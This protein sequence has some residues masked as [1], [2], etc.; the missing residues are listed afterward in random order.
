MRPGI[1]HLLSLRFVIAIIWVVLIQTTLS[2]ALI[3]AG[4]TTFIGSFVKCGGMVVILAMFAVPLAYAICP[5]IVRNF[6]FCSLAPV[7]ADGLYKLDYFANRLKR[8]V[9][10]KLNLKW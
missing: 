5:E 9:C 2:T 6:K 8:L 7:I 10:T 1:E 3:I 4:V